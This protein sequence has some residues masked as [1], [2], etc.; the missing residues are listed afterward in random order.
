M[1]IPWQESDRLKALDR[2]KLLDTAPEEAFD[3]IV[4]IAAQICQ[5][6][7]ALISLVDDK[8]QWFKAALGVSAPETPRDIAFCAHA[9]EQTDMLIV[10]DAREDQRFADNPLVTGD[11]SLRFYAGARL[12]T[13]DGFP[14][15]TLCVLDT[16]PGA[17][18]AEQATALQALAR[19]VMTQIEFRRALHT[20]RDVEER[21]RLIL[22]SA[23]DYGIISMDLT[24]LVTSWNEGAHRIFGW[25]EAEMCGRPCDDFFT[26]EDREKG[27]PDR[28]MGAALTKGRGSDERWH[29]RKDGSRFW[30]SG[31]MMPLKDDKGEPVGFL[32]ILRDRTAQRQSETAIRES[33]ARTRL[34]V[35]AANLGVWEATS[36]LEAFYLDDRCREILGNLT[37]DTVEHATLLGHVSREDHAPVDAA[38]RAAYDGQQNALDI[39]FRLVG[40]DPQK[41]VNLRGRLIGDSTGSPRFIGTMRDISAEKASETL[42]GLLTRELEH[43][44]K[45]ILAI[46]QAIVSQSLRGATST[47]EANRTI[48]SRLLTLGRAHDI[49]TKS[50][51][52]AAPITE[53]VSNATNL[54][55]DKAGRIQV[56]GPNIMLKPKTA[57]ALSM[58]LHELCTNA[59]KYGALSNEAGTVDVRWAVSEPEGS[60]RFEFSW[61]EA[62]GPQVRVPSRKGFGSRLIE[63]ALADILG[64]DARIEFLNDGVEWGVSAP[65]ESVRE[66]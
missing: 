31:E 27:V 39:E 34:A 22:E 13:P 36:N 61:K 19:Q 14:L 2:Y 52:A 24:G 21:H 65:L 60:E 43:R 26:E 17:L 11:M 32:K 10:G 7:M 20:K 28:E 37:A 40:A 18:T 38:L 35:D 15:G 41:W 53:I 6:P 9:I 30:A 50:S 58:A 57:L 56:S 51:W 49:L 62:G 45:N 16:K 54:Y 48:G 5:V 59:A 46:V 25:S 4:R 33:E 47:E 1:Q 8:R 42:R 64:S 23:I 29:L 55:R 66:A 12:E 44:G 3:D 63:G